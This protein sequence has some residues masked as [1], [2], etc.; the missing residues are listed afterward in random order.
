MASIK[1]MLALALLGF[2]VL[3]HVAHGF[4]VQQPDAPDSAWQFSVDNSKPTLEDEPGGHLVEDFQIK[5]FE[6]YDAEVAGSE[7]VANAN[8]FSDNTFN[9]NQF[10]EDHFDTQDGSSLY[11]YNARLQSRGVNADPD[12]A[13]SDDYNR[14]STLPEGFSASASQFNRESSSASYVLGVP[15]EKAESANPN[16]VYDAHAGSADAASFTTVQQESSGD[17]V[18]PAKGHQGPVSYY[19]PASDRN[20]AFVFYDTRS[21]GEK[22]QVTSASTSPI[23]AAQQGAQGAHGCPS[24]YWAGHVEQWPAPLKVS[25][26]VSRAFAGA[27]VKRNLEIVYGT[28]TLFQGLLD[29]RDNPYSTLLRHSVAA[30]LNARAKPAFP[31]RPVEVATLFNAVLASKAAAAAQAHKFENENHAFRDTE[32]IVTKCNGAVH[33]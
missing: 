30:L 27:T 6:S 26:F 5:G 22:Q 17:Q 24:S 3:A 4:T 15:Q 18:V 25:T 13:A 10:Q 12:N 33:R 19:T 1:K 31:L 21:D 28:T 2:C 32:C 9:A 23:L 8:Q 7:G 20:G 11:V 14:F 29:T 16:Y